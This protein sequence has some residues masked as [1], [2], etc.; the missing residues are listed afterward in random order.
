MSPTT[1][2]RIKMRDLRDMVEIEKAVSDRGL[3]E[4]QINKIK[5][6]MGIN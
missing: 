2:D 1:F 3:R 4:K 6:K 5:S